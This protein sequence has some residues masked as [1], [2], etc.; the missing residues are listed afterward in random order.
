MKNNDA[1]QLLSSN[2]L[3][4]GTFNGGT[5]CWSQVGDGD[6]DHAVIERPEEL[7]SDR[8]AYFV[9]PSNPG[10]DVASSTASALAA[11]YLVF[12]DRGEL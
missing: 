5:P 3:T 12:K 4:S 7:T 11:G 10:T 2:A 9:D 6:L 8:P 1:R